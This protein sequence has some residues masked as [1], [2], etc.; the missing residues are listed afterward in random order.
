[1]LRFAAV[2][3]RQL[4]ACTVTLAVLSGCQYAYVEVDCRLAGEESLWAKLDG[5]RYVIRAEDERAEASLAF[6]AFSEMLERGLAC[7]RP[8]LRR[9]SSAEP[10]ELTLSVSY[11]IINQGTGLVTDPVYGYRYGHMYG[12]GGWGAYRTYGFVGHEVRPAHL[13]Y[14]HVLLASAW[15]PDPSRPAGRRVVWEGRADR[16][17][18]ARALKTTMPSLVAVLVRFYGQA[19]D[20]PTKI[21]INRKDPLLRVLRGEPEPATQPLP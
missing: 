17:S 6:E 14:L 10:A 8:G 15:V 19:T 9:V 13:G 7:E 20:Q 16:S 3:I 5:P 1:M 21:K 2:H 4:W 18:D 12:Y 11:Q